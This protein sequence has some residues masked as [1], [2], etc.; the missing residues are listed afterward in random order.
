[1]DATLNWTELLKHPGRDHLVEVYQDPAFLAETV[2]HYLAAGLHLGEGAIVIAR[3]ENRERFSRA[4]AE[5]HGLP[6]ALLPG[7]GGGGGAC[8]RRRV[9]AR[10]RRDARDLHGERHSGMDRLPARMRRRH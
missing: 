9:H 3:A 7:G 10:R 2:T 4:L 8:G 6:A 1:M 5:V